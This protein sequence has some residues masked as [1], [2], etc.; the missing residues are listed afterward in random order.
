[1]KIYV[2]NLATQAGETDLYTSS[3]H[4]RALKEHLGED[5]FDLVLCNENYE[6][7]LDPQS[8]WVRAD[9]DMRGDHRLYCAD[10]PEAEHPWRHDSGKLSKVLL[11]LFYERTGPLG[12]KAE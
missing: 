4:V 12:D 6:G 2:C 9:N 1:M 8:Q 11:D 10:L 5:L 7:A 3:D